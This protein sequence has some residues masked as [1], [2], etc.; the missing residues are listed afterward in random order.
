M[1]F[2]NCVFLAMDKPGEE[3]GD[4]QRV[5]LYAETV[6]TS[7]FV[8]EMFV[9]VVAMGFI[10]GGEHEVTY[11]KDPWNVIDFFIVL[12]RCVCVCVCVC[13]CEVLFLFLLCS[14]DLYD[15]IRV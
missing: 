11:L 15:T 14:C 13:V 6:F 3:G 9:K 1:I 7:I 8:V 4:F 10:F 12:A 5:L 2:V